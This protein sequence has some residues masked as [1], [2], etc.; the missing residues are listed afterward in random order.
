MNSDRIRPELDGA[1]P[2]SHRRTRTVAVVGAGASGILTVVQLI[3]QALAQDLG[4]GLR[5]QLFDKSGRFTSGPAYGT[6]YDCHILNM[7]AATMSVIDGRPDDF[8]DWLAARDEGGGRRTQRDAYVPRRLYGR[9]LTERLARAADRAERHG[10]AVE[11]LPL[12]VTD[13]LPGDGKALLQCGDRTLAC[14]AAVLCSGDI[15][16]NRFPQL[17]G[18]DGY[19]PSAWHYD[20]FERIP[21]HAPVVVLGSS[22]TA[23]DAVLLLDAL[24]HRG[25]VH[26]VSR[27]RSLPKVQGGPTTPAP[28]RFVTR[29]AID[30]MAKGGARPLALAEVFDLYRREIEHA[31]GA[32]L[33]VPG[34]LAAPQ[35]PLA[36]ALSADI[37][38]A[39]EGRNRWYPALDATGHLAP[40][41]WHRLD[42]TAKDTFLARYASLWAMYRH[43]MPLPNARRIQRLA[44]DGRLQV[45]TGFRSVSR[46]D[47]GRGGFRVSCGTDERHGELSAAYVIN[48]TGASPDITQ[49]DDPLLRNLVRAGHLRPHR[50]GGVDVQFGTGR[51]IAADGVARAPLY[52]VGPLT[53]GVHFYTNSIETLLANASATAASLLRDL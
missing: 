25:R 5:I 27:V 1:I 4:D 38:Q 47:G 22:L 33:N 39:A 3:E 45:H 34:L 51:A 32:P 28:S 46:P 16:G 30:R 20:A 2:D 17:T 29:E 26:C 35:L 9:Y 7:R 48:A 42:T 13:C 53:R 40:Y 14:D 31:T 50:H 6:P 10:V 43:S 19:L 44:A 21:E 41:L 36:D 52:F 8:C 23:V 11:F 12:E 37:A 15:P 49:L 24:G 18:H